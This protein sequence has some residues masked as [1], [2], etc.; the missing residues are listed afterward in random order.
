M[1]V[2]LCGYNWIG[3]NVLDQLIREGNEVFVYTHES[4][5]FVNDLESY[6]VKKGVPFSLEPIRLENVPFVPDI[7]VSTY[8]R[9]IIRKEVID[10]V[11]GRIFNLHPSLL[12]RY[13]G[14]SSLTWAMINGEEFAGF[15]YHYID[16]G[17]DSGNVILQK[18]I[19]IE[20]YDTQVTLYHRVMFEA[21]LDFLPAFNLVKEGFKGIV[22]DA[23]DKPDYYKRGCPFD[24]MIDENWDIE[25]KE[26]FI[27]AMVY[28]PLPPAILNGREV[29]KIKDLITSPD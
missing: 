6:C 22:Q 4:P 26:R 28:P 29:W 8:Y 27:R 16:H 21:A 13:R 1:R 12:P 15:T 23:M 19:S 18:R 5:K 3:C 9:Y 11:R 24:G 17:I 20:Q 25:R 14:C 7:I 2:I 10:L